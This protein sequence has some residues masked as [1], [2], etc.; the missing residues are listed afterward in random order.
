MQNITFPSDDRILT[1]KLFTPENSKESNPAALFVHGWNSSKDRDDQYAQAL[2]SKGYICM[3]FNL[4]GHYDS[5]GDINDLSRADYVTDCVSAYDYLTGVDGV[6]PAHIDLITSS[7]GAHMGTILCGERKIHNLVLRVPQNYPNEGYDETK[8]N[9]H[10]DKLID[11]RNEEL[12]HE[13]SFSLSALHNFAGNVLFIE[14]ETDKHVP[15]RTIKNYLSATNQDNLT[16]VFMKGFPH[17][18]REQH[19]KDAYEKI[20]VDWL[21]SHQ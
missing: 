19:Q 21:Q 6:N 20:L 3:V 4:S 1:G 9:F 18:L 15:K 8:V 2:A 7:M 10:G 5:E 11:W 17:S 13:D 16:Y 12:K 14:S